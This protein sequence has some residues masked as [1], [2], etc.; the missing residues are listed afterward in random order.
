[1]QK[2][3]VVPSSLKRLYVMFLASKDFKYVRLWRKLLL[4]PNSSLNNCTETYWKWNSARTKGK[5]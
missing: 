3:G 1:M 5:I 2:G 4:M